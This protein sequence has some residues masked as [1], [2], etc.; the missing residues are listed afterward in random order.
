MDIFLSPS[1][2]LAHWTP[3]MKRPSYVTE[4][5]LKKSEKQ[6]NVNVVFVEQ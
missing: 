5:S 6:R 3:I 4:Q 2:S 1:S